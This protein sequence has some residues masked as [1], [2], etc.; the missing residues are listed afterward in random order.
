MKGQFDSMC[1]I[2][3]VEGKVLLKNIYFGDDTF[4]RLNLLFHEIKTHMMLLNIKTM[5]IKLLAKRL[6]HGRHMINVRHYLHDHSHS[7]PNAKKQKDRFV[8]RSLH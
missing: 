4:W 6:V 7:A 8:P 5:G 1:T 2:Q 3:N